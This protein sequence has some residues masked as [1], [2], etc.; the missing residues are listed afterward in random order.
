MQILDQVEVG[1]IPR[2][3]IGVILEIRRDR[4]WPSVAMNTE[5]QA[6]P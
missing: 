1:G 6:L 5:E 4:D 2:G 3:V